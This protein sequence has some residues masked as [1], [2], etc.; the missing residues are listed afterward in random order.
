MPGYARDPSALTIASGISV[1]PSGNIQTNNVQSALYELDNEK[2]STTSASSTYAVKTPYQSASASTTTVGQLWVDS[3][4]NNLYVYDGTSYVPAGGLGATGGGA[5]KAF[6]EN[7][8]TITTDYTITA[9]RNAMSTGPITVNNGV[10]VTV[11]SGSTWTV[12]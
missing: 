6:Y 11:P 4:N 3:D 8:I 2:L 12:I 5:D 7:D 9:G 1:N 10:T